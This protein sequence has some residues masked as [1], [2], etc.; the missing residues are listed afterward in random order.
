MSTHK[1]SLQNKQAFIAKQKAAGLCLECINP[2]AGGRSRCDACLKRRNDKRVEQKAAAVAGGVCIYCFKHPAIIGHSHCRMCYCRRVSYSHFG[3]TT[4]WKS[5]LTL[6]D[7][8]G[9]LCALSGAAMTLGV[10]AELDHIIPT[11]RGGSEGVENTQWVLMVC[12][13]MKD[14]LTEGELFGLVER[15]YHTMKAKQNSSP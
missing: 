15:I 12:N 10:D 8:Q 3:T 1:N 9:G 6:W 2:V 4:Q 7:T 14:N 11:S 13:R 5:L